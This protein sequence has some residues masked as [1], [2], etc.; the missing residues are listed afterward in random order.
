MVLLVPI[1]AVVSVQTFEAV[2]SDTCCNVRHYDWT[3]EP[4][5][6]SGFLSANYVDPC[7][8][9]TDSISMETPGC[10]V[11]LFISTICLQFG[12]RS[13]EPAGRFLNSLWLVA[14]SGFHGGKHRDRQ[15]NDVS[16]FDGG[17]VRMV[18]I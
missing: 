18:G 3:E 13:Q 10:I 17:N 2:A 8:L 1:L 14:S 12:I 15:L 7:F 6:I 9:V 4:L 5:L 16:C 11:K